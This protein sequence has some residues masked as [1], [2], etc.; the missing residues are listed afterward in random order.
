MFREAKI[1]FKSF[2]KDFRPAKGIKSKGKPHK[3]Q[4]LNLLTA[5]L[6]ASQFGNFITGQE[7]FHSNNLFVHKPKPTPSLKKAAGIKFDGFSRRMSL[8][9]DKHKGF[10]IALLI[11][12][13]FQQLLAYFELFLNAIPVLTFLKEYRT[14]EKL[15]NFEA[16]LKNRGHIVLKN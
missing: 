10:A 4:L 2:S 7:S 8:V 16:A 11:F 3:N 15:S 6:A 12:I 5:L 14:L 9:R 13:S 1:S